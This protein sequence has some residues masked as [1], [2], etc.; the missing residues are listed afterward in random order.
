MN[1]S[2]ACDAKEMIRVTQQ[3]KNKLLLGKCE[4]KKGI[5]NS[6]NRND[7]IDPEIV[8]LGLILDNFL[9]LKIL[10]IINP[11]ISDS[12]DIKIE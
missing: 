2:P 9:P 12:T 7:P 4:I 6:E 5:K 11:P 3:R 8:F 10:P 1:K